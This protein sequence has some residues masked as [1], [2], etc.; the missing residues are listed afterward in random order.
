MQR[1]SR[2]IRAIAQD[3]RGAT[4]V[5]YAMIIAALVL[6]LLVGLSKMADINT[7]IWDNIASETTHHLSS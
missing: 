5:E 3:R 7:A 4:A 6:V 2:H 1:L